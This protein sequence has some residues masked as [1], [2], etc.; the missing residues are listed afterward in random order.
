MKYRELLDKLGMRSFVE[1]YRLHWQELRV[2]A[3]EVRTAVADL[4]LALVWI[5][6]VFLSPLAWSAY[7][8]FRLSHLG[9]KSGVEKAKA[10][11]AKFK[12][13]LAARRVE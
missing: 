12:S 9:T 10:L 4:F 13:W 5:V 11:P 7:F 8:L 1:S 2:V 3:R 6:G